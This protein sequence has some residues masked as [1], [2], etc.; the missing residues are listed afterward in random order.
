M[1]FPVH[2]A[3][4][5][6]AIRVFRDSRPLGERKIGQREEYGHNLVSGQLG[7]REGPKGEFKHAKIA[8]CPRYNV[9][10]A[11]RPSESVGLLP[12]ASASR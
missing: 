9:V 5:R 10:V 4:K 2:V 8:A 6:S 11:V 1:A 12:R 7:S 3:S